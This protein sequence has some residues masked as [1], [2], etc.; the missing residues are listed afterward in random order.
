MPCQLKTANHR[1]RLRTSFNRMN[2]H[3]RNILIAPH[4]IDY[5]L[6]A[7]TA[8]E[9]LRDSLIPPQKQRCGLRESMNAKHLDKLHIYCVS[10]RSDIAMF[11]QFYRKG[12]LVI[13]MRSERLTYLPDCFG[14]IHEEFL[15]SLPQSLAPT[16]ISLRNTKSRQNFEY[17]FRH[18]ILDLK[19]IDNETIKNFLADAAIHHKYIWKKCYRRSSCSSLFSRKEVT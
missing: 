19:F 14:S 11:E 5:H 8:T 3:C 13:K 18:S 4:T 6:S 10:M 15:C 17:L 9:L 12:H 2:R 16:T 7:S 1:Y